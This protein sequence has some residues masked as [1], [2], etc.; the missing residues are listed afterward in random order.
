MY[1]VYRYWSIA[2]G[3][4]SHVVLCAGFAGLVFVET[5]LWLAGFP[6]LSKLH[7]QYP[8][9]SITQLY[10]V[11][12]QGFR[13]INIAANG[14]AVVING[15]LGVFFAQKML[16]V[17]GDDEYLG[18]LLR[19]ALRAMIWIA[20]AT[21]FVTTATALIITIWHIVDISDQ[22]HLVIDIHPHLYATGLFI[23]LLSREKIRRGV[24]H[25]QELRVSEAVARVSCD[26]HTA[27]SH[28]NHRRDI[29]VGEKIIDEK[30]IEGRSEECCGV[31]VAIA[32]DRQLT[33][34]DLSHRISPS[35]TPSSLGLLPFPV[36][37]E[38]EC[39]EEA[40][41]SSGHRVRKLGWHGCRSLLKLLSFSSFTRTPSPRAAA[42]HQCM[43]WSAPFVSQEQCRRSAGRPMSASVMAE[44]GEPPRSAPPCLVVPQKALSTT[45]PEPAEKPRDGTLDVKDRTVG[46][47]EHATDEY[48]RDSWE[49]LYCKLS[50]ADALAESGFMPPFPTPISGPAHN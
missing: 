15:G 45:V 35:S 38:G 28:A 12:A 34:K 33:A 24:Q 23:S 46:E 18:S 22:M 43:P 50:E 5:T 31:G 17:K 6:L 20:L 42:D 14:L 4:R 32:K 13:Y 27:S 37:F 19:K 39:T 44:A 16:Q 30:D 11:D 29:E 40:R 21:G 47:A 36:S 48:E 49:V 9:R 41:S 2:R 26:T 25:S 1:L 7:Q 10:R 8:D 3:K